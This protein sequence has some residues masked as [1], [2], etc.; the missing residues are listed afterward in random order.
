MGKAGLAGKGPAHAAGMAT[1]GDKQDL[2]AFDFRF[3]KPGIQLVIDDDLMIGFGG[4]AAV[5]ARQL[6]ELVE[7]VG[8]VAR[9]KLRHLRTVPG[10][11]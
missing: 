7:P 2:H 8:L 9:H 4:A 1:V 11:R 10:H 3:G 5:E 6:Q